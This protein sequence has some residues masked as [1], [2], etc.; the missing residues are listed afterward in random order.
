[1]KY[2][3][4]KML[5]SQNDLEEIIKEEIE[6]A[7]NEGW[8]DRMIGKGSG[9]ASR[10]AGAMSGLGAKAARG[11]GADTAAGEMEAAG[12]VRTADAP[13]QEKLGLMKQHARK[14]SIMSADMI[15]D[16][17]KLGLLADPNFKKALAATK[18]VATRLNNIV[19]AWEKAPEEMPGAESGTEQGAVDSA[20]LIASLSAGDPVAYT[21][22]KGKKKKAAVVKVLDTTDAQGQPQIQ[23]KSGT[24]V[25]AVDQ[26]SIDLD[27]EVAARQAAGSPPI[28]EILKKVIREELEK[29][30]K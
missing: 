3:R 1:M 12:A 29:L 16:A 14:F 23:L 25:F 5:I 15:K 21:D 10:A 24:A 28:R 4:N 2:W 19:A 6:K 20:N 18:A 9:L 26:S 11:L 13:N 8:L 27:K 17:Q 30:S 22:A 7:I